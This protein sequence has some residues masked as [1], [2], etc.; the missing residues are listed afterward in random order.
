MPAVSA[1]LP[2]E[3]SVH[4]L[5]RSAVAEPVLSPATSD[6]TAVNSNPTPSFPSALDILFHATQLH[7]PKVE[8]EETASPAAAPPLSLEE[9]AI[10]A[11]LVAPPPSATVT[12]HLDCPRPQQKQ[13]QPKKRGR[14]NTNPQKMVLAAENLI[15]LMGGANGS[16]ENVDESDGTESG[17]AGS[18]GDGNT[19]S[20]DDSEGS[21]Y[22]EE[23]EH[24]AKRHNS[25]GSGGS[26]SNGGTFARQMQSPLQQSQW[27]LFHQHQQQQQQQRIGEEGVYT[28]PGI[29]PVLYNEADGM[30]YQ[31][32]DDVAP[33]QG[34]FQA[35]GYQNAQTEA[36]EE[37]SQQYYI[38][39]NNEYS[40]TDSPMTTTTKAPKKASTPRLPQRTNS[41]ASDASGSSGKR[42][43][44]DQCNRTFSRLFNLKSHMQTHDASRTRSFLCD[45]CGVGFCRQ[46]DLMR[47]GTVHDK[48]R[49]LNCPACPGKTFSRKDALRRHIRLNGCCDVAVLDQ[50]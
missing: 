40:A 14:P 44:C 10:A 9:Q 25:G 19:N 24:H 17:S 34:Y 7:H 30:Y 41:T 16:I 27:A 13:Q 31:Q 11:A 47:H 22:Q 43:E 35:Y 21:V 46:Q 3:P 8:P 1:F 4:V 49:T 29:A 36:S 33:Q 48:S 45:V 2:I 39:T 18:G 23:V 5:K 32:G 38:P 50:M 26:S 37:G 15:A 12:E 20:E 6:A 28:P 42:Y